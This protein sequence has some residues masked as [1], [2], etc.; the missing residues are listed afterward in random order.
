MWIDGLIPLF[1]TD[2]V[3]CPDGVYFRLFA[4]NNR[5]VAF[6][7]GM[8]FV[9]VCLILSIWMMELHRSEDSLFDYQCKSIKRMKIDDQSDA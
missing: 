1:S 4:E 2:V 6:K 3:M 5:C 7:I 9:L 8:D